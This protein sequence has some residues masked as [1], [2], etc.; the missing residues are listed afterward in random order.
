MLLGTSKWRHE[1]KINDVVEK[2]EKGEHEAI[3]KL[4]SYYPSGALGDTEDGNQVVLYRMAMVDFPALLK[5]FTTEELAIL[6]IA[7]LEMAWRKYP[8]GNMF[9]IIDLGFSEDEKKT[10]APVDSIWKVQPYISALMKSVKVSSA[11]VDPN[12]PESFQKIFFV[13]VPSAFWASWKI[14]QYFVAERT[15]SKIEVLSSEKSIYNKIKQHLPDELI[16]TYLGGK[17]AME[18][19]PP[20]GKYDLFLEQQN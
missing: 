16:P 7:S 4:K 14:A 17:H 20:G 6:N 19:I 12:F 15:R 1:R 2:V 5:E 10:N 18:N 3:E 8:Q 11:E 13:R 9:L